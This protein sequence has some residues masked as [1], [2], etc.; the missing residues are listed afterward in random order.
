M[1][2]TLIIGADSYLAKYYIE[3]YLL[4]ESKV[5]TT[6]YR[7]YYPAFRYDLFNPDFNVLDNLIEDKIKYAI[8]F[9]GITQIAFCENNKDYS[10]KCNVGGVL[11]TARYFIEKK[12]TP[13][14]FSSDYVFDGK[15]GNYSEYCSANPLNEY[16]KQKTELE[17]KILSNFTDKS[18]VIRLSKVFDEK[19]NN[20]FFTE[21]IHNLFKRNYMKLAYDQIFKPIN[22]EELID[23]IFL[24]QEKNF[25]GLINIAGK[26]ILSR[27]ELS[28]KIITQYNFTE[29]FIQKISIDDLDMIKRPKNIT[30]NCDKLHSILTY[31]NKSIDYYITRALE[32][33]E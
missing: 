6:S 11:K 4:V 5:I 1:K 23:L 15:K 14:I 26:E 27:Y 8:I 32:K 33:Y 29:N 30:L 28:Q 31:N 3:K 10:Y 25:K 12:I 18:I 21:I 16:G 9:A 22:I 13:I 2:P 19:Q 20:N 24:L 7:S 17:E